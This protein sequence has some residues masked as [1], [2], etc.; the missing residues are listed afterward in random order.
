MKV[1]WIA[2]DKFMNEKYASVQSSATKRYCT[3][4]E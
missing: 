1:N 3:I 2:L 4:I